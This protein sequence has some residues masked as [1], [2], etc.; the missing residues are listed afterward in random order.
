MGETTIQMN[1]D[2]QT[3]RVDQPHNGGPETYAVKGMVGWDSVMVLRLRIASVLHR[4][5]ADRLSDETMES[6]C[7]NV[8]ACLCFRSGYKLILVQC[9]MAL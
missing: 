4:R 1:T 3:R 7:M 8:N 5:L 2:G 6:D 9:F